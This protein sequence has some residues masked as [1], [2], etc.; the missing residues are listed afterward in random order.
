M[1]GFNLWKILEL[2]IRVSLGFTSSLS[3]LTPHRT[4]PLL[5]IYLCLLVLGLWGC[6]VLVFGCF[7]LNIAAEKPEPKT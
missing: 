4:K 1:G 5:H 6:F 2:I 7:F 3:Q